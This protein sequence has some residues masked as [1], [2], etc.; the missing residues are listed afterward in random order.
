MK[1]LISKIILPLLLLAVTSI[2]PGLASAQDWSDL[3]AKKQTTLGLYM[4][5]QMAYD[6]KMADPANTLFIDI[7]TPEELMFLGTATVVD[8]YIPWELMDNSVWDRQHSEY[9]LHVNP[10]FVAQIDELVAARGLGKDA[11]IILMCRSGNRSAKGADLLAENGYTNVYNQV[12]GYEGD[13][14]K[15]GET[16]GQRVV[17]GWKNAGLP[18]S[19]RLDP[20]LVYLAE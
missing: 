9:Q 3:S 16:K 5:P 18:W 14:S 20:T 6:A 4:T 13:K 15:E 17:N 12:E 2:M 7:R 19:Y 8:A 11:T 10:N 1:H